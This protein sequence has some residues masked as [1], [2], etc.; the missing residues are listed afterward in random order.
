MKC[1]YDWQSRYNNYNIALISDSQPGSPQPPALNYNWPRYTN[2]WGTGG[3]S[4]QSGHQV[5]VSPIIILE[6]FF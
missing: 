6:S 5:L 4:P 1:R 3:G 2:W